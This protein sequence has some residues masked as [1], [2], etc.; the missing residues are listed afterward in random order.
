MIPTIF[1]YDETAAV[2]FFLLVSLELIIIICRFFLSISK[3]WVYGISSGSSSR[4]CCSSEVGQ[5]PQH[6]RHCESKIMRTIRKW[7][8]YMLFSSVVTVLWRSWLTGQ[9][10]RTL[11]IPMQSQLTQAFESATE[12]W[13]G[14]SKRRP[15]Q[16]W[17]WSSLGV[18]L[19]LQSVMVATRARFFCGDVWVVDRTTHLSIQRLGDGKI[20]TPEAIQ[21]TKIT[22]FTVFWIEGYNTLQSFP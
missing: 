9:Q 15:Q 13:H 2:L 18:L 17:S 6:V 5:M 21:K 3:I 12:D 4:S 10:N 16:E 11:K 7:Y 14:Q 8:K 19:K 20:L 22:F 1:Y